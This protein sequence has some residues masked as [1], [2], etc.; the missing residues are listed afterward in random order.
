LADVVDPAVVGHNGA[1]LHGSLLVLHVHHLQILDH[2][3]HLHLLLLGLFHHHVVTSCI[4]LRAILHGFSIQLSLS[5]LGF[6]L[7]GG[8]LSGH[9]G[10]LLLSLELGT[11]LSLDGLELSILLGS[12]SCLLLLDG[13]LLLYL[14]GLHDGSWL[15]HLS[16][17]LGFLTFF[18]G[19][20]FLLLRL[21]LLLLF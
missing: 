15:G 7:H 3:L 13:C 19:G 12:Y 9:L 20:G 21:N 11:L 6:G 2:H 4:R 8:L 18:L 16:H 5:C 1:T 10:F 14:L 17:C